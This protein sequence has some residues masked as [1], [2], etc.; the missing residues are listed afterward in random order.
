MGNSN[1]SGLE[2]DTS[3]SLQEQVD[4]YNY[5]KSY[6]ISAFDI[7]HNFVLSYNYDLPFARLLGVDDRLTN[8]WAISGIS[9]RATGL[10]VFFVSLGDNYLVQVQNNGIN[11]PSNGREY[12]NTSLFT[13][14]A[15]GTP[16]ASSL[17]FFYSFYGGDG[18]QRYRP[19]EDYEGHRG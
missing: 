10:P 6:G 2:L 5:R 12:F 4:P 14:N 19:A 13:P 7:K 1:Y 16:G 3:S 18:E 17:R 9:R 11:D 8:G 15:L